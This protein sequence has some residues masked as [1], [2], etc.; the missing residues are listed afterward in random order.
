MCE[1]S[2]VV[3]QNEYS[4]VLGEVC[5]VFS[6]AFFFALSHRKIPSYYLI[7]LFDDPP[8]F[9]ETISSESRGRGEGGFVPN[10]TLGRRFCDVIGIRNFEDAWFVLTNLFYFIFRGVLTDDELETHSLSYVF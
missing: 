8:M 4:L 2:T 7:S 3:T 10:P 6:T 1:G 9:L 5:D